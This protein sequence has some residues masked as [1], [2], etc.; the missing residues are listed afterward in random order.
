MPAALQARQVDH[1]AVAAMMAVSPLSGRWHRTPPV[2][3]PLAG[4]SCRAS[5][6]PWPLWIRPCD[7]DNAGIRASGTTEEARAGR[8]GGSDARHSRRTPSCG[9]TA[10]GG[11][12]QQVGITGDEHEFGILWALSG[13]DHGITVAQ[14]RD[15]PTRPCSVPPPALSA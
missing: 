12:L 11:K 13:P 4:N 6:W 7:G 10:G 9:R 1:P 15:R 3:L 5:P 8:L 2:P 14:Q